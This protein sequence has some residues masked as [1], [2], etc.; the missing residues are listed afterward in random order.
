MRK[1]IYPKF[2]DKYVTPNERHSGK[3]GTILL[4]RKELYG[5]ARTKD[6]ELWLERIRA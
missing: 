3:D 4:K 6:P 2:V 1:P 5:K